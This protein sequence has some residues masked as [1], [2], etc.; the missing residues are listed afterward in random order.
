[1]HQS[2]WQETQLP[3][4]RPLSGNIS[5]NTV[6]VGGGLA[7]LLCAYLLRQKGVEDI[8]LIDAGGICSGVTANTTAKITSQHG[9]IYAK[10]IEGLGENRAAQYL[11]ANENAIRLY[12]EII[13]REGIECDFTPCSAWVYTTDERHLSKIEDELEAV[14]RL[15]FKAVFEDQSE[16][17]FPIKGAIG[18]PDQ[19]HFHPLKFAA[20]ICECLTRS[21]CKIHTQTKAAGTH[22]D[23]VHTDR[24]DIRAEHIVSCS[25]YPFIDKASLL[26]AR[27]FQERAYVLAL[28]NAGR[29]KDMHIGC[30]DGGFS[31]RP[32]GDMT[33]FGGYSHKTGHEDYTRHFD[34]LQGDAAALFPRA[35]IAHMWS[36][37]DCMTHDG[38]PYIGRYESAGSE[39]YLAAG[40]NKWGMTSSMA[41]ADILS[42]MIVK[43]GSAY[44]D[45]FCLRRGDAGLQ[46]KSF[47]KEGVDIAGNFL[48]HLAMADKTLDSLERDEGGIVEIEGR[49]AGVYKDTRGGLHGVR[50]V[51]THMGCP[52]RWNPDEKTWDCACHGSRFDIEG[53][54]TGGPAV[55]A[56][57]R[58]EV[59]EVSHAG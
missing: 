58:A 29:L 5:T 39:V 1:M 38:I 11:A 3:H 21:G 59:P 15:G 49:H 36:A 40:F 10:L 24:G 37:Q 13:A 53:N 54:V 8:T 44:Q 33:L 43:S 28:E 7:G 46:A 9:L 14:R 42:D 57:E 51:C 18:F 16:L 19:A 4:F 17:P 41:A 26:F 12:R 35:R 47:L 27:I 32:C 45:A 56:L 20:G 30:A 6:I 2:I 25:H 22:G 55:K 34:A 50:P 23:I 52:V 31:F 48:S